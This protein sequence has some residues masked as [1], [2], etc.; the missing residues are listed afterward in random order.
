[1]V[2]CNVSQDYFNDG[3]Y[4][5]NNKRR[6]K[7][8]EKSEVLPSIR[9]SNECPNPIVKGFPPTFFSVK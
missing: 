9:N 8:S 6:V 5:K 2:G 1:M 7:F 4:R 3:E